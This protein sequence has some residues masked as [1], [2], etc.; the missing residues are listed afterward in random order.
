ML[1]SLTL[2]LALSTSFVEEEL[3]VRSAEA[4]ASVDP[5][6]AG[7]A[8]ARA[9]SLVEHSTNS[10]AEQQLLDDVAAT[11]RDPLVR[12]RA[13]FVR[14]LKDVR[15]GDVDKAQQ[16]YRALGFIAAVRAVGPFSNTGGAGFGTTP[17]TGEGAIDVVSQGAK[18]AG[19]E[20]DVSWQTVP[21]DALGELDLVPRIAP[22]RETRA[23]LAVVVTAK[24]PLP[25]VLRLGS[26]GQ[27]RVALN[28]VEVL[29][30]D[31]D[32]SLAF[33]QSAAGLRL[34][35]GDNLLLVELGSLSGDASIR[36]R[37]SKP[38]GTALA[39]VTTSIDPAA[40]ARAAGTKA[41]VLAAPAFAFASAAAP[42]STIEELRAA[43]ALE[44]L[45]HAGD[46][47]AKPRRHEAL[48]GALAD[49][50]DKGRE[51]QL[52]DARPSATAAAK[53][54]AELAGVRA[55]LATL[56]GERDATSARVQLERALAADPHSIEAL[57][58]FAKLRAEQEDDV[59][60]RGY[61]ARARDAAPGSDL[62]V[63]RALMYARARGHGGLATDLAILA[64]AKVA[65]T[66][67]NLS[68]AADVLE[69]RGDRA[70]ALALALITDSDSDSDGAR[71]A[72]LRFDI[73]SA[74]LATGEQDA[75]LLEERVALAR[76][77]LRLRPGSHQQMEVL[78]LALVAAGR[79]DQAQALA[80]ARAQ[81]M[82][83]RAEPLLL[84]SR[85]ALIAGDRVQARAS[86]VAAQ[87]IVPQDAE[88][89]RALRALDGD[90][91]ELVKRYGLDVAALARELA[92]KG[93]P[94]EALRLGAHTV[95]STTAIRFFD[96]G[97]GRIM[98][99][100]VFQ[101]HDAQKAQGLNTFTFPYSAGRERIEVLLAERTTAA[102]RQ[103]AAVRIVDQSPQ[104]KEG[105]VY[106]DV[107]QKVV[108]FGQLQDGDLIHVRTR[109]ELTGMQNLF[110]DFFG[111]LEPIQG[112][113][114][115]ENWRLVVEAPQS[116]PLAWHGKGAPPPL[117]TQDGDRRV[118]DFLV[119]RA[120][121][122]PSEPG[123]PPWLEL[124]DFTS[125]STYASWQALGAW[126]ERLVAP[127]LTLDA[128][129]K[130]VAARVRQAAKD[131]DDMV[132]LMYEYV[133]TQ[134][135][136]VGI[137]LGIHGW[138]PYPVAEV[139][140]R[141]YGDCKDKASLLVALL[142]E[143]GVPANIALVRTV[144]IG[145]IE[146]EPPSMWTF[147]HA[148]AYVPSLDL[149]LDGTAETSGWRE[150]PHMD[151]GALALI[152]GPHGDKS[153][154]ELVTIPV[155]PAEANL[156][157]SE[158]VLRLQRDG[159]LDVRGT[160]TFR[161]SHNSEQRREFADPA[162]RRARLERH[163]VAGMPGTRVNEIEVSDLGLQRE[164]ISYRFAATLPER[165]S[166]QGDGSLAM[167][168]SLYPHDLAGSYAPQSER[169]TD[170]FIDRPW[171]TRNVMR[172]VLPAGLVVNDLPSGGS[173]KTEHLAFTQTITR[174]PDGFIVDE[175]TAFLVRRI[176]VKDYPR[177]REAALR[178]DALMKRTIRMSARD[179]S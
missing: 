74:R 137:E 179:P 144:N 81:E 135:R 64:R 66:Q 140:R 134:T 118:Y 22:I 39:G 168:L 89:A 59:Q 67:G 97:L 54:A 125:V 3:A 80:V 111:T 41:S 78:A 11:A 117:I 106:T 33:D 5:L 162:T 157:V 177:L 150:T 20:R 146:A 51:A 62:A 17:W 48:L 163:L 127:Q 77:L 8:F 114:P 32:R 143:A 155:A 120:A 87:R 38:D 68:L 88:L 153:S 37:L 94:P 172:Y 102:G 4:V 98:T 113:I 171:R 167:A 149:F 10:R 79:I 26:S 2:A 110:G 15:R 73:A 100:R 40:F 115:V 158:Y 46:L 70:G 53:L 145:H 107:S 121:P 35:R 116:R 84:L 36:L 104:G 49:A 152:V 124:A 85:L 131:D 6:I 16:E 133:V 34:Q 103:E 92:H 83:E 75:Q 156:N 65:P 112:F 126:Y 60:A 123:M 128:E 82:C 90:D 169:K 170:I 72:R 18:V 138:L 139:H 71:V 61:Y 119:A 142:R 47:R 24:G 76:S 130:R 52:K 136:Y 63:R 108:V 173:V 161:G 91:D 12:A 141:R 175:D 174:T 1:V 178:A 96:N 151:Q 160:E 105:G 25:A 69:E 101:V 147:N 58:A 93:P 129:L 45:A 42:A 56:V 154:S 109:K 28:G 164:E 86:L 14:A 176:P 122:V 166:P 19:L 7:G 29:N 44:G 9:L 57:L 21:L 99:D 165:A 132:R 43:S 95:A 31:V 13:S 27:V 159:S 23:L 55:R 148:I 50:L 30:D